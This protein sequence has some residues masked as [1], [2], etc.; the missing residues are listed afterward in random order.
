IRE[1]IGEMKSSSLRDIY[2]VSID[3]TISR[4][5]ITSVT[6]FLIALILFIFGGDGIRGFIF[7]IMIGVVVGTYSSIF[8]ASPIALDLILRQEGEEEAEKVKA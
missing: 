6:T 4:T 8:V 5:L 1:N 7:A 3:Q 2:N